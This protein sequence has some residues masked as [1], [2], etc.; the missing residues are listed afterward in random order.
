[1]QREES[2]SN[3]EHHL[4]PV[5]GE[6]VIR[7]YVRPLHGISAAGNE[8]A[9][10]ANFLSELSLYSI[11]QMAEEGVEGR[12]RIETQAAWQASLRA[13][14]APFGPPDTFGL[15]PVARVIRHSNT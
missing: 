8:L 1:M 12:Q 7:G 11:R 5:K 14:S 15:Q 6:S 9:P 3:R 13:P 4:P 2:G 10:L